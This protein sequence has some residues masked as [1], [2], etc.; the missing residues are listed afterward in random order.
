M[1]ERQ[2]E[3]TLARVRLHWAIF[4]P[5]ALIALLPILAS[6]PVIFLVHRLLSTLEQSGMRFNQPPGNPSLG[7]IWL[8][9][10]VPYL[11]VVLGLLLGT[12]LSYSKSEVTL[13]N[14]R[15]LFRTGF[16]SRRSGELPLEN[17]ESIYIHEPLMG[18]VFGYGTVMVSTVGG[19]NFPMWFIGSPQGFHA[20]L[21]TAV[22]S[23]KNSIGRMPKPPRATLASQDDESRYMPK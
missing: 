23:A 2:E 1:M 8:L 7:L 12:W 16:L 11:V 17:V 3:T 20:T 6:L 5:L 4:V 9:P 15:L 18:R 21:Q 13:T 19:A 10:L 22:L 14:R